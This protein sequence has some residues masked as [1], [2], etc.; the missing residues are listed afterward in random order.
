MK[1]INKKD[2]ILESVKELWIERVSRNP[3]KRKLEAL[4]HEGW[5]N[6][7]RRINL[8]QEKTLR[9]ERLQ[10]AGRRKKKYTERLLPNQILLGWRG[11]RSRMEASSRK[12]EKEKQKIEMKEKILRMKPMETFFKRGLGSKTDSGDYGDIGINMFSSNSGGPVFSPKNKL[13]EITQRRG[14]LTSMKTYI[15]GEKL[16][17]AIAGLVLIN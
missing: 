6:W 9:A 10:E 11:W 2:L 15:S 14:K 17:G 4:I 7:W 12:E 16:R 5:N 1:R 8:E 3:R 13:S